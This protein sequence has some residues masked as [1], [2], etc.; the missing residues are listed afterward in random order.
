[1]EKFPPNPRIGASP[2]PQFRTLN[3]TACMDV[4][5]VVPAALPSPATEDETIA[6]RRSRRVSFAEITAVHV[7][8]RDE[9]FETPPEERAIAV[10]YPSPSPTPSLSPGK[11]AAE[12]GEETE[13][14]EEEFL[15]PPFRFLNNGD[16]DSSSPGSAAGSLVSNDGG[17]LLLINAL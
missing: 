6:R 16:V 17:T 13:G 7:F 5:G 1:M 4:A 11:P 9:D 2:R 12:E 10:G 8:D 15:R 14:E 3:P